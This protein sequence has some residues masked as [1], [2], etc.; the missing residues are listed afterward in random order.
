MLFNSLSVDILSQIVK[1]AS[2]NENENPFILTKLTSMT[3]FT[4]FVYLVLPCWYGY[5]M[6]S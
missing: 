1:R 4:P 2:G 3:Q 5:I 6:I